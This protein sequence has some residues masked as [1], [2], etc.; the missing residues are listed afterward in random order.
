[1]VERDRDRKRE[2]E[3]DVASVRALTRLSERSSVAR[4]ADL[5]AYTRPCA[6]HHDAKKKKKKKMHG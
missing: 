4:L 1:M 5:F 6:S 2:R 3:R